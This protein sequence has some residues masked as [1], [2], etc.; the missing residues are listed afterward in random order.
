MFI[1]D[2]IGRQVKIELSDSNHVITKIS[3]YKI[4]EEI[5]D[6]QTKK[7]I[8]TQ[9]IMKKYLNNDGLKLIS[10]L[11][12]KIIIQNDDELNLFTFKNE[13]DSNRFVD[14]LSVLFLSQ[15][16]GDCLFVKDT[17]SP[18]K[19]YLYNLLTERGY[20]KSYLF[21]NSTTHLTGK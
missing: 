15:K 7:K 2:E 13:S 5:L 19:K 10:K 21:R 1:K 12:N 4:E 3:N 11:N 20:P 18:Q 17:S 9:S 14:T 16:R 6:Y 8:T